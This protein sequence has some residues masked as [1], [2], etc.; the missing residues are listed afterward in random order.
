MSSMQ[1]VALLIKRLQNQHHKTLDAALG[2]IGLTLV[3]WDA[4]RHLSQHPEASL[5]ALAQ[6]TFQSDQGFGTLAAR[7]EDR[8]LVQREAGHGRAVTLTMTAKGRS[9]LADA[10]H[11]V[12]QTLTGTL[13][14]LTQGELDDLHRLLDEALRPDSTS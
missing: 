4:L 5:H 14:Q 2:A 11:V 9:L 12:D 7:M 13:G 6:L 3:Q 10:A 8:G 1:D